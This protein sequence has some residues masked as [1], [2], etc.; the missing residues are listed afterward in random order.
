MHI[1]GAV[2]WFL[3]LTADWYSV[4]AVAIAC[5]LISLVGDAVLLLIHNGRECCNEY[6]S[7]M[8]F[9]EPVHNFSCG[10]F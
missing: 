10:L 1:N 3:F 9:T 8:S 2:L 7:Y 6:P 4:Q 5:L